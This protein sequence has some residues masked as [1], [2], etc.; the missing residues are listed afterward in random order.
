[1][2]LGYSLRELWRGNFENAFNGA[3]I[4]DDLLAAQD[5]A[6]DN[7]SK[8]VA[9]QQAEG[10]VSSQ[11]ASD[12]YSLL[13]PNT[14]SDAYWQTQGDTPWQEFGQGI[15]DS[16]RGIGQFG[17]D[18]INKTL[19]VGFKIIPWQVYVFGLVLLMIWLYPLW[20]PF[21]SALVAGRK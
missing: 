11:E 19:G 8:I 5:Q 12:M 7:L 18:A 13:S 16:A 17:S 10:L 15:E 14:S 1:M 4:S 21:A 20:R 9:R 3:F 2:G 6:G